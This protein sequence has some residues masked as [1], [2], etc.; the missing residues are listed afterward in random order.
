MR[1]QALA[2]AA[3]FLLMP[4]AGCLGGA[5]ATAKDLIPEARRVAAAWDADASL[6]AV[7]GIELHEIPL[8]VQ[9]AL[10]SSKVAEETADD[11]ELQLMRYR[12]DDVGDGRTGA[13]LFAFGAADRELLLVLDASGKELARHEGRG[14]GHDGP[15]LGDVA[16][17]SDQATDIAAKGNATYAA[18][19]GHAAIG[20]MTLAPT[21][22]GPFWV[23]MLMESF[24][25]DLGDA[26]DGE[27][28]AAPRMAAVMVDATN[29]TVVD[30][31]SFGDFFD[32]SSA[33]ER[34]PAAHASP[35][36]RPRGNQTFVA[37][38]SG[39]ASG[40]LSLVSPEDRTT[41]TVDSPGHATLRLQLDLPRALPPTSAT[42]TVTAP[43]GRM[44][45]LAFTS[46]VG[47]N[48][49]AHADL[50][51]PVAGEYTVV[52][53]LDAGLTQQYAFSW[54]APGTRMTAAAADPQDACGEA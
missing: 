19:R 29:G 38:E 3:V 18:L 37:T 17:D 33:P 34:R 28:R 9:A 11:P 53:R 54:C 25:M 35:Y 40:T 44:Q 7:G 20:G 14:S 4:L 36:Y 16:I 32:S 46:V 42:A 49:P 2:L 47:G 8:A 50:D 5:M 15:A 21:P 52:V 30:D 41:F 43:D 10:A 48:G 23:L 51:T 22:K 6:Q 1:P 45:R 13:W 31:D 27:E 39:K 12:D 26:M 24:D